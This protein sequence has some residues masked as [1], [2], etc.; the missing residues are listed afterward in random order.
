MTNTHMQAVGTGLGCVARINRHDADASTSRLVFDELLQLVEGPRVQASPLSFAEPTP[1][2][3]AFKHLKDDGQPMLFGVGDQMLANGVIDLS[4]VASLPTRKPF[5]CPAAGFACLLAV[6]I[7]LRLQPRSDVGAVEA[8]VGEV[9]PLKLVSCG[10]RG[11]MPK[12][13]VHAEGALYLVVLGRVGR[14][15]FHLNVK[16]KTVFPSS[17]ERRTGGLL[18]GECLPLEVAQSQREDATPI[19]QA[20]A[21]GLARHIQLEDAG[22]VVDAGGLEPAVPR[23]GIG[24]PRGNP[25]N[26]TDRQVGRQTK[27]LTHIAVAALMQIVLAMLLML[28]APISHKVAGLGKRFKRRLKARRYLGRNHQL[29]RKGADR[30]HAL[31]YSDFIFIT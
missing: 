16:V 22:V 28:I 18:S 12:P 19:D 31:K 8:I 1:I 5:E 9:L 29:A 14:F 13:Q 4:L 2:P 21:D 7:C 23:L 25:S 27:L 10:I 17:L 11:D 6:G 3:N 24:H 15:V 30:F 20:Q 26:S